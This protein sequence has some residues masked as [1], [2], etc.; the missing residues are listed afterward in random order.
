MHVIV[1]IFALAYIVE[2]NDHLEE[3]LI[4]FKDQII[5]L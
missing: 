3:Y 4:N 5:F 2:V 1:K